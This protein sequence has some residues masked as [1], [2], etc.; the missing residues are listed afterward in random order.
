ME[1]QR[2]LHHERRAATTSGTTADDF[3]FVYKRLNGNGSIVVKV[4]SLVNTNAW[5]KAGVMIRESLDAGSKMAY[6]IESY[7]QGV[8]FGWRPTGGRHLRQR[9]P[10]GRRGSAVGEADPHG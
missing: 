3:R 2:R 8:S 5:A 7:S 6:M 10:G 4:E 1:G 9:D